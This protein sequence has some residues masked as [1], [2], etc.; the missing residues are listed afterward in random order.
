MAFSCV[1]PSQSAS[2]LLR[3]YRKSGRC[4]GHRFFGDNAHDLGVFVHR[5]ARSTKHEAQPIL[6]Q[7]P[8]RLQDR[9]AIRSK[10]SK[11]LPLTDL[12]PSFWRATA[13]NYVNAHW[14]GD[15]ITLDEVERI[16]I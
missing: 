7:S 1:W 5:D 13:C 14:G 6:A 11:R 10:E 16:T 4:L 12:A 3:Q 15:E 8:V 9:D 2:S